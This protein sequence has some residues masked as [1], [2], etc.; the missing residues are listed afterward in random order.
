M[1]SKNQFKDWCE[2]NGGN[3]D[4]ESYGTDSYDEYPEVNPVGMD[5]M[6]FCS[7]DNGSVSYS[8]GYA[9]DEPGAGGEPR[10]RIDSRDDDVKGITSNNPQFNLGKEFSIRGHTMG[11]IGEVTVDYKFDNGKIQSR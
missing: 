10:L 1:V 3:F 11:S 9:H 4:D 2:S 5:T 6:Y 8:S 7:F